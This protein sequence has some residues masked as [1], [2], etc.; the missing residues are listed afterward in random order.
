LDLKKTN[1]ITIARIKNN[2]ASVGNVKS[3][4]N[5]P[6]ALRKK[7]VERFIKLFFF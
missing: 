4:S 5:K 2:K 1:V 7:V 3:K 6:L